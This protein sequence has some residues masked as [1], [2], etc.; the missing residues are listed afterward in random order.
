MTYLFPAHGWPGTPCGQV[1]SYSSLLSQVLISWMAGASV[2]LMDES[3]PISDD[4]HSG[5][6]RV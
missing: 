4:R 5:S 3:S 1:N 6:E 2:A